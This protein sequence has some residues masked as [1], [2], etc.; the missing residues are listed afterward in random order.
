MGSALPLAISCLIAST[1]GLLLIIRPALAAGGQAP[2]AIEQPQGTW[3]SP[4][5]IQVPHAPWQTPGAIQVPKGIQ[6]IRQV[7]APCERRLVVGS[8]ALFDFNKS[9]LRPDA[10]ETLEALGPM[11]QKSGSRVVE[12]DG[13]T[14]SIGTDEYNQALSERRAQTVKSWLAA[15]GYVAESTMIKGFG[16]KQ[17]IAPNS[18]PDG[19]D[20]PKGRQ[21]NRRVEIVLK[22]CK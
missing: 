19:S 12:I 18:N 17:P 10:Q 6:A 20:D 2:G 13:Y 9:D 16:K 15:H 14:D 22:I 5:Q 7:A 4:G 8:D 21:R 11:I 1:L 3:Q